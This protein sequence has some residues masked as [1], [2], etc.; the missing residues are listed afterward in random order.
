VSVGSRSVQNMLENSPRVHLR[1]RTQMEDLKHGIPTHLYSDIS[2]A[3][4]LERK[5][6]RRTLA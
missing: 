1:P 6:G 4:K 5:G 3:S 2:R